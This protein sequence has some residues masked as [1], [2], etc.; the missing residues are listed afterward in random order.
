MGGS[1]VIFAYDMGFGGYSDYYA[2]AARSM[3]GNWRAF[4][5][6]AFDPS[7]TI[8]LDKLAGFLVPQ[9]LSVRALG[10]NPWALGLPQALEGQATILAAYAVIRRWAGFRAGVFGA[11]VMATT[12][13]LVSM[14]SHPMEDAMLTL[15]TTLAVLAWQKSLDTGRTGYLFLSAVAVGLGFQAKMMQA[16]LILPSLA[17]VYM[18]LQR[19]T[20]LRKVR[21]LCAAAV[22][23]VAVSLS[24]MSAIALVPAP[25]RPFIDGTVDNNIYSMVFGF[26]GLN[27]YLPGLVPGA[28]APGADG[29]EVGGAGDV[30]PGQGWLVHSPLKLFLPYYST[31]IGWLYPLALAGLVLGVLYLRRN[32]LPVPAA[33][34]LKS[35]LLVSAGLLLTEGTLM[36]VT[37]IP[38][39]VYLASLALP[40]AA[41]AA[42]GGGLLW[43]SLVLPGSRARYALSLYLLI[44][45]LWTIAIIESS[46][47]WGLAPWLLPVIG[48]A[49]FGSS[50]FS[51]VG[52]NRTATLGRGHTLEV[53]AVFAVGVVLAGPVLWSLSTLDPSFNGSAN[54]AYAGPRPAT[55]DQASIDPLHPGIYGPGLNSDRRILDL[56]AAGS[57]M[58]RFA[59][60]NTHA[61]GGFILATDSWRSSAPLIMEGG[62]RLLT[63]GGYSSTAPNVNPQQIAR[64]VAAGSLR[65]L[66]LTAGSRQVDSRSG[67]VNGI[68]AWVGANCS[69][70]PES[71]YMPPRNS[72]ERP[73]AG[74]YVLFDCRPHTGVAK[75]QG[76]HPAA[77]A[78]STLNPPR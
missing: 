54:D 22:L 24:W 74:T 71:Q 44:Q 14:F 3:S 39:P 23:T 16:W 27:R 4:F 25:G 55:L 49:G 63:V 7:A 48:A 13:L 75:G 40:I 2:S 78:S 50:L 52:A 58:Y 36:G 9:A 42:I 1:G 6:G 62:N 10:F 68:R 21:D 29:K 57:D 65:F 15:C 12:P 43:R 32:L 56:A 69:T 73:A 47:D 33:R 8:T 31:Q 28:L 38:H 59:R 11:A 26:N 51:F 19:H 72:P 18:I 64:L 34:K 61:P 37:A 35:G 46:G 30:G 20:M 77:P 70:V 66:L 67:N 45:T 76:P 17:V 5:F 41:L 60:L 53:L